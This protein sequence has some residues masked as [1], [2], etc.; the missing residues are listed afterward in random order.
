MIAARGDPHRGSAGPQIHRRQIVAHVVGVSASIKGIA[1]TQLPIGIGAPALHRARVEDRAGMV[2]SRGNPAGPSD[3]DGGAAGGT[4]NRHIGNIRTAHGAGTIGH[5]AGLP[6]RR[7][8][9]RDLV[10][11]AVADGSG[12]GEAAVSR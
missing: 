7:A 10:D 4:T 12:E 2:T 8:R 9:H 1:E 3:P 5:C 11:G 6:G